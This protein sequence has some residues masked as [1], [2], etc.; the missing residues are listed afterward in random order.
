MFEELYL[1]ILKVIIG[2]LI[3]SETVFRDVDGYK[4]VVVVVDGFVVDCA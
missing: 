2:V 1:R 4:V 3:V